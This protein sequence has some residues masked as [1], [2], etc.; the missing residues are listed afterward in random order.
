MWRYLPT[1]WRP[2]L[3]KTP[4]VFFCQDNPPY[5]I[6]LFYTEL[7]SKTNY[8]VIVC[9]I[10]IGS[11]S[12]GFGFRMISTIIKAF[13]NSRC[14]TSMIVYYLISFHNLI[15]NLFRF[16][17]FSKPFFIQSFTQTIDLFTFPA[18]TSSSII[19]LWF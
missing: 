3:D 2:D 11:T 10:S 9:S 12:I 7:R 5:V 16:F 8:V 18:S 4:Y 15:I 6:T 19:A 17:H 1:T 13:V 14:H